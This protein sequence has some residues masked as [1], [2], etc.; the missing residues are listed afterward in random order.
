VLVLNVVAKR[1]A[2]I[3][4]LTLFF[5]SEWLVLWVIALYAT[6]SIEWSAMVCQALLLFIN[7]VFV[8][9]TLIFAI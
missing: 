2:P 1:C 7:S 5:C 6:L 4:L 8:S 3:V 9:V